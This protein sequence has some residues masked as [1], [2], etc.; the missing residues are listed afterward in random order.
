M[1]IVMNLENYARASEKLEKFTYGYFTIDWILALTGLKHWLEKY[2]DITRLPFLNS[3]YNTFPFQWTY[4][5]DFGLLGVLIFP[6]LIGFV[7][8]YLY[9]RMRRT[10]EFKWMIFYS[11]GLVIIGISFI[12]NPLTRLDFMINIFLIYLIFQYW[13]IP[14][15]QTIHHRND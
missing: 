9:Y 11:F 13:F 3:G 6:F 5:N 1:Y 7:I 4:Y 2:Y 14:K 8:A 12:M 10:G 15:N